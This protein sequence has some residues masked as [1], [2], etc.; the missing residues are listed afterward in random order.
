MFRSDA[1]K[2]AWI[3][4]NPEAYSEIKGTAKQF[5][6]EE[7]KAHIQQHPDRIVKTDVKIVSG[8]KFSGQVGSTEMGE[9]ALKEKA[10]LERLDAKKVKSTIEEK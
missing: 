6:A 4:A 10:I 3:D 1:E 7:K 9:P 8:M 2:Q 5:T